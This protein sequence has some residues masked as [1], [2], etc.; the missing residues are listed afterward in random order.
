MTQ[1]WISRQ[2]GPNFPHL[3][4]FSTCEMCYLSLYCSCARR[5][6][7]YRQGSGEPSQVLTIQCK[8]TRPRGHTSLSTQLLTSALW[9]R[10]KIHCPCEDVERG[11]WSVSRT[12]TA[13]K[14]QGVICESPF[15]LS[16]RGD[17]AQRG[18]SSSR[19]ECW[20]PVLSAWGQSSIWV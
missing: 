16:P 14:R 3:L 10:N 1:R 19:E 11:K 18:D 4:S 7:G 15:R 8:K 6:T 20:Q 2:F 9:A 12:P 17:K 13:W 5:C